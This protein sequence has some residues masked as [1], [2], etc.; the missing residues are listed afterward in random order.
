MNVCAMP[1]PDSHFDAVID[2]GTLDSLLCGEGTTAATGRYAS[3][4]SRILKPG[5]SFVVVS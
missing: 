3:E 4:I 5:G 2:K 1:F